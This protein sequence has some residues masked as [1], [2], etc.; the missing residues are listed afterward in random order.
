MKSVV[1]TLVCQRIIIVS[2]FLFQGHII[3]IIRDVIMLVGDS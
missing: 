3:G 2:M 1:L